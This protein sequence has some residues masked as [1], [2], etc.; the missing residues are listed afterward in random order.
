MLL[1]LYGETIP[2]IAERQKEIITECIIQLEEEIMSLV[3]LSIC[4]TFSLLCIIAFHNI[5]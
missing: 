4:Y 3:N 1:W 5:T 2:F